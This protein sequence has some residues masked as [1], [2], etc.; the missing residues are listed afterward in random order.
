MRFLRPFAGKNKSNRVER[1][2]MTQ[3]TATI[4]NSGNS[5][6]RMAL[7][8]LLAI[9]VSLVQ[10]CPSDVNAGPPDIGTFMQ[11]GSSG[12]AGVD[13]ESGNMYFTSGM[14]GKAQVYRHMGDDE[15]PWQL[16][17]FEDG[18]NSFY[19][20]ESGRW[21]II[22]ASVGGSEQGQLYLM[23]MSDGAIDTLT[24]TELDTIRVAQ[25]DSSGGKYD[26]TSVEIKTR[27]KKIQY[28]SVI[29]GQDDEYIYFRSDFASSGNYQVYKMN[30]KTR[31]K[32]KVFD[33][34]DY[35]IPAGLTPDGAKL[36]VYAL[37]GNPDNDLYLVD[38]KTLAVDSISY[39]EGGVFN[40]FN[41]FLMP[42]GKTVYLLSNYND[43]G[44]TRVAKMT[45]G[46]PKLEYIWDWIDPKWSVDDLGYSRDYKY[47]YAIVNED[48]YSRLR[49]REIATGADAPQAP[50]DGMYSAPRFDKN[51]N[52]YF[53]FS[54]PTYAPDVWKFNLD[55]KK[56]NKLSKT[57]YAGIDRSIF[58]DPQLVKFKSFDGLEVPA[59]LYLPPNYKKGDKIPFLVN[60]HGGPEGQAQPSF[61]RSY[62][63]FAL[64]GYGLLRVNPRGSSGYGKEYMALDDYKKRVNSLK[65]YKA[66]V[67]WLI[68]E[69]YTE[70]GKLGIYGGSYGGYVTLGMI[71]E[72]PE[73]FSAAIDIVGIS[74]FVSFLEN[75]APSR[76]SV[77]EIEYGPLTD[78]PF[79]ESIS[80][81]N[82]ADRV[83]TPL[84]VIH[85]E[86]DPRVP[87]SEA[88]Q[89]LSAVAK[90]GTPVDSLIFPDEGH[91]AS[92]R[93]NVIAQYRKMV[94][95]FDTYLKGVKVKDSHE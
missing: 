48:G 13:W 8:G 56:L 37:Q 25:I 76:R 39:D 5:G 60:A 75:T 38:L 47:M 15:W 70:A 83:R 18:I 52:V 23:D 82:K 19:L 46:N 86:N 54:G 36:F 91:G 6:S 57:M 17:L 10:L 41:P 16:S 31:V 51:G 73:L 42:D 50:L 88:R 92:K 49:I 74:N 4:T 11:I 71:T 26:T 7:C 29:W 1:S 94:D 69:N 27:P 67:D 34:P 59:F 84:L 22:R 24:L 55:S 64:S 2:L 85:G 12:L 79:L 21:G 62:Q 14:S 63:Y 80:P 78:R 33:S 72:Y 35:D 93:V 32:T 40:H 45:V 43:D 28:G 44:I 30:I 66:A 90:N 89:M 9:V 87:V 81:L 95:F 53:T 61:A 20:S 68:A 65:D 77:R 3:V 58:S